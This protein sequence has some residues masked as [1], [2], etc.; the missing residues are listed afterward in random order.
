MYSGASP[1]LNNDI[2]KKGPLAKIQEKMSNFEKKVM[3]RSIVRVFL[4]QI[5]ENVSKK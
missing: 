3:L 2:I 4:F 1:F 5:S